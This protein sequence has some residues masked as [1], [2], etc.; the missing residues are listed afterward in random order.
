MDGA[1]DVAA[2]HHAVLSRT[3]AAELNLSAGTVRRLK[4]RGVL[5]EPAPGALVVHGAPTTWRQ[6]MAVVIASSGGRALVSHRS[7]AAMHSLEGFAEGIREVITL[8]GVRLR[9]PGVIV[10]QVSVAVPDED[11]IVIDGIP[12]T[13]LARTIVDLPQVV[14][15]RTMERALD[16]FE[17]RGYSLTWLEQVANRLHRPGQ[18]GT[19][20]I[21]AEV[22]RRR[23]RGRVRGSWFEKLIHECL[24]SRTLPELVQQYPIAD[25]TG[26]TICT[27]DLAIPDVKL[28]LECHSRAFHTGTHAEIVDQRR[29]NRA[30]LEG[31]QFLYLGWADRKTPPQAREYLERLV[32]RRRLDLG[33]CL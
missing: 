23:Q 19:K 7:A 6:R 14:D 27:V 32:A 31:W 20:L 22:R 3:Q 24:R 25:S 1:G 5:A 4:Q 8:R 21:L 29:E 16:D 28:A 30:M 26:R 18:R 33:T 12:C 13:T 10:H 2:S 15:D 11:I 9:V 17:R